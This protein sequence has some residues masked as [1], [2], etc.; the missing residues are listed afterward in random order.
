MMTRKSKFGYVLLLFFCLSANAQ[1]DTLNNV[2][3]EVVIGSPSD[4][5]KYRYETED[6]EITTRSLRLGNTI[7]AELKATVDSLYAL[8]YWGVSLDSLD[9]ENREGK[10]YRG[11]KY[12]G[13]R[14]KPGNVSEQVFNELR[15]DRVRVPEDWARYGDK[16]SRY[17]GNL[18]YP[19]AQ[20]SLDSITEEEDYICASLK[21][22]QG[23]Q[24]RY[25]SIYYEGSLRLRPNYLMRYLNIESR[26][27]YRH[28]D[29]V[30]A[31]KLLR[32]IPFAKVTKPPELKFIGE[33]ASLHVGLDQ[34]NASRFDLL[35]GVNP[36]N[37]NGDTRFFI[38]LDVEAE[39]SNQLQYGEWIKFRYARLRPENQE[40]EFSLRYPYVLDLPIAVTGNFGLYRRSLEFQDVEADAGIDYIFDSDKSIGLV[41]TYL[42]SRL[43]NVD[44]LA[45]LNSEKLPSRLDVVRNGLSLRTS[46]RNLDQRLNPSKGWDMQFKLG[47]STKNIL[48]NDAI[49]ELKSET[50]DF[51]TAYDTLS[52][53]GFQFNL[54]ANIDRYFPIGQNFALKAYVDGFTLLS[55]ITIY[56]NEFS[57]IGGNR[58]LRGFDEES[59]FAKAYV[60]PGLALHVL[61][62]EYSFLSIPFI[63]YGFIL[64]T[65]GIWEQAIGIGGGINFRTKAGMLN[66]SVAAGKYGN[67]A[68]DISRPKV[69]VGF[70]SL[71]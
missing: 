26:G 46:W 21:L 10:I 11:Q 66:F 70:L 57:R 17:L 4:T 68:F 3:S 25:D 9:F 65:N 28:D 27:V 69:H 58:L 24:I 23:P 32:S 22:N 71:F 62:D 20:I 41:W 8:G 13:F 64:S 56:E 38:T 35:V 61:L 45:V 14:L 16:L 30:E 15:M 18:G 53:T 51:A 34:K 50:V 49:R 39:L 37:E 19:F 67:A 59:I 63:D 2:P 7:D 31:D 1:V 5:L 33:Y 42:A 55:N 60:I 12:K 48:P 44:S 6:G 43:I 40:L 54:E 29:V 36:L 52:L 47:A